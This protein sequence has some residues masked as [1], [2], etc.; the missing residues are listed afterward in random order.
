M[1]YPLWFEQDRISQ[2]K[3]INYCEKNV[4]DEIFQ[5]ETMLI[6]YQALVWFFE[7]T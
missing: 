7:I 6:D 5:E 4:I 3:Q 2:M 1:K